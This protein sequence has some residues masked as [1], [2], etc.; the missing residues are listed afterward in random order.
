MKWALKTPEFHNVDEFVI[1][2]KKSY[3][4]LKELHAEVRLPLIKP[5]AHQPYFIKKRFGNW[6]DNVVDW[7]NDLAI[8]GFKKTKMHLY[9]YGQPDTGK[10]HFVEYLLGNLVKK[11]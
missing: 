11:R 10:T 3:K 2:H 8:K 7:F 9:L 1:Q 5:I 4:W 6:R